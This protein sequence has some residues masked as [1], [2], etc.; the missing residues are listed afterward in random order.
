VYYVR[1]ATRSSG[2]SAKGTPEQALRYITDA[3]DAERDPTYSNE[4]LR[5]IARL[6]SGWKTDL[7][8]GRLRLVGLGRLYGIDDQVEL[9]RGFVRACQPWHDRRG[10]TGYLSYTFTMPKELS[11]LAEGHPARARQAM[12]AALQATLDTAFPGKS[13]KA[14]TTVHARNEA[15]EVHYHAHVLIGKFARDIVRRRTFSLNSRAGGNTGKARV[16][17]LKQAWK[18][19]LDAQ[20]K[21]RLGLTVA[22]GASFARPTLTLRNGSSIPPLNRDSRRMLDK[23]LCARIRESAPAGAPSTTN[24]RWTK[25][26]ETIYELASAKDGHGWSSEAFLELLPELRTR[27]KRYEARVLTLKSI[28]YLTPEGRVSDAFALHYRVHKG[29]DHPELQRLRADLHRAAREPS[30]P[31]LTAVHGAALATPPGQDPDVDLWMALHRHQ[32]LIKRLERLGMPPEEFKGIEREARRHRLSPALLAQLRAEV[33]REIAAGS[34]PSPAMLRTKGVIQAYWGLYRGRLVSY[35][36]LAKGLVTLSPREH[37][38]VAQ[39]IR[40]RAEVEYFLAKEKKLALVA[41]RLRPFLWVGD[42][43]M[44]DDARRLRVALERC[45]HLASIQRSEQLFRERRG[46]LVRDP[47]KV[48][49]DGLPGD[50]IHQLKRGLEVLREYRPDDFQHLAPWQGREEELAPL[51][52]PSVED[53]RAPLP[54]EVRERASLAGRLGKVLERERDFRPGAVPPSL[55]PEEADIQRAN[56][57]FS[58]AG[59]PL[60]FPTAMLAA[61]PRTAIATALV[62]LRH[63]GFLSEGPE[64]SLR[65]ESAREVAQ[66][67]RKPFQR[68]LEQDHER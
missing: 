48:K 26:D 57:R 28:G 15:G 38:A 41:H 33:Q 30:R 6:D 49:A 12:Y 50:A 34:Q 31:A 60:P 68:F 66:L 67:V 25:L 16:A 1:C 4:E 45:Q 17:T 39:Q 2:A 43:V 65:A 35:F 51:V 46:Q 11:L 40:R 37:A 64:W 29:D 42:I 21:R 19:H 24:F 53:R 7:E 36:V 58:A 59:A 10:S 14:V 8:G 3:H 55:R 56:A 13:Y 54:R 27:L 52:A 44:P 63:A 22:Q 18:E 47:R 61:A 20:L 32:R 23:H 5:Y 62:T 9:A